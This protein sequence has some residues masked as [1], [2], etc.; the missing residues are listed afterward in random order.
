V[1]EANR[2]VASH[3]DIGRFEGGVSGLEQCAETF[4]FNHAESILGH[5]RGKLGVKGCELE[6]AGGSDAELFE[7]VGVRT[8]DDVRADELTDA[9]GGFGAS[10][11]GG[12]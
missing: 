2:F 7:Q 10:F 5:G 8:G 4:G 12:F 11:D 6:T 3:G 9:F 1:A